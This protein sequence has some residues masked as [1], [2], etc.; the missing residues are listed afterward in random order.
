MDRFFLLFA[1]VVAT[2]HPIRAEEVEDWRNPAL[3]GLNNLPPHAATV[4]CPDAGTVG[5]QFFEGYS[6]PG[7]SGKKADVRWATLANANGT[8]LLVTGYPLPSVNAMHHTADDPASVKHAFE[9]SRRDITILN[10]DWRQQGPGG[11]DSWRAWPHTPYMIP[12]EAQSYSFRPFASPENPGG[13]AR[14]NLPQP[15][16]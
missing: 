11:D 4:V 10:I 6:E 9:L 15:E 12:G 5:G 16:N 2:M 13:P 3:T 1:F 8:G 7:E 14:T